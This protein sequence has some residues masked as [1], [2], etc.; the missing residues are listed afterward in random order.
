MFAV[1]FVSKGLFVCLFHQFLSEVSELH[2]CLIWGG[3]C[4]MFPGRILDL[5]QHK[6]S[7]SVWATAPW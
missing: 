2:L 7:Q 1:L 5:A 6:T 3:G 4:V